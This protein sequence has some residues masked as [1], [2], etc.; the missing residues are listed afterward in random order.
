ME[1][2]SPPPI[3]GGLGDGPMFQFV[4]TAGGS[5]LP[6]ANSRRVKRIVP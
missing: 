2:G 4:G 6:R 5:S 1:V 3:H